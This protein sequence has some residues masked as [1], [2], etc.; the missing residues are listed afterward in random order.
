MLL[1]SIISVHKPLE[2]GKPKVKLKLLKPMVDIED[3]KFQNFMKMENLSSMLEFLVL[4]KKKTYK[5]KLIFYKKNILHTNLLQ[6]LQAESI[7]KE[8]VLKPFWN[9]FLTEMSK[10]LWFPIK[11]DGLDSDLIYLNGFL[12]NTVLNSWSLKVKKNLILNSPMT[13]YQSLQFS[14]LNT[15]VPENIKTCRKIRIYP[16]NKQILFFNKCFGTSRYFYNKAISFINNNN[17]N[18]F[19]N[20]INIRKHVLKSNKILN[21]NELWQADIP[22]DTRQLA[23]KEAVSAYKSNLKLIKNKHIKHFELTYKTKKSPRQ[24]FH[25]NKKA[26]N[27]NLK[28]FCRIL[29]K[30]I[31]VRKRMKKWWKNNIQQIESDF[32]IIRENTNRYYMCMPMSKKQI[33]TETKYNT[34]SLDPGVRTFQTFYSPDGIYGKFGDGIS[35][36]IEVLS[37]RIDKLKKIK[38]ITSKQKRNVRIRCFKLTTK[39]KN[40]VKDLHYK[41]ASYLCKNFKNIL[42]PSF[43]VKQMTKQNKR[44]IG[45]KTV[46]NMLAL[47]HYKFKEILKY[48]VS[49]YTDRKLFICDES[50]TSKT[51]GNCGNIKNDLKGDKIYNCNKCKKKIDRDVN[52]ARNVLLRIL[53][54]V[55]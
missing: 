14:H 32:I 24:M 18:E 39:I 55:G 26:L 4:N 46:R 45:R 1:N 27:L 5:D 2:D 20:L 41:T 7:L 19:I 6:T 33:N 9:K 38:P 28:L 37:N 36:I 54:V 51:C 22:Y 48:K 40:I 13:L 21:Y 35:N 15:T 17:S 49:C 50:Y 3:I 42:L 52:G 43:N 47:S 23:I 30:N 31:R 34:V 25:I 11:T 29:K 44:K 12:Q 10:K 8:K 16:N 53:S